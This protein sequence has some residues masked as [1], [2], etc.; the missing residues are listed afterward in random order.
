MKYDCEVIIDLPREQVVEL[1]ANPDNMSKWQKGLESAEL[2]SGEAGQTGAKTRLVY[3]MGNRRMEMVE[4]ILEHD[5]PEGSTVQ[6]ETKGV[7]NVVSNR[8]YEEGAA[9]TR[10]VTENEFRFSGLMKLMG[11][12]MRGAFP[13]QSMETM[14]DFKVFAEKA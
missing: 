3:D 12:F 11:I 14:Q 13:K 8:F 1:F 10:W 4:T 6:Y 2:V 7:F 5:L 9:K